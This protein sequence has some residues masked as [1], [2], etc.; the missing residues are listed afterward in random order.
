MHFNIE[1]KFEHAQS[2]PHCVLT[3]VGITVYISTDAAVGLI[4]CSP[5]ATL[6]QACQET[7]R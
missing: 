4:L 1:L 3:L 2:L 5:S 7:Y 6:C